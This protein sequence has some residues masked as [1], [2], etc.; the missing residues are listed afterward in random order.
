MSGAGRR[1]CVRGVA[2]GEGRGLSGS[3]LKLKE[4]I[5]KRLLLAVRRILEQ[6][7]I[8]LPHTKL[9]RQQTPHK[10]GKKACYIGQSPQS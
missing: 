7:S 10:P 2:K 9:H 5:L 6:L 1:V 8:L 3:H 4:A